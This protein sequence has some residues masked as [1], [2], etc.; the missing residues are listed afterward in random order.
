MK[1]AESRGMVGMAD[2]L[3]SQAQ[4]LQSLTL[5]ELAEPT[6]GGEGEESDEHGFAPGQLGRT[7]HGRLPE[8]TRRVLVQLLRGPYVRRASHPK[9]WAALVR[10]EAP[11]REVLANLF[12]ELIIDADRSLAF[13]RN[14]EWAQVDVPRVIRSTPLT[15]LD[16][17]LVLHLRQLLLRGTDAS[18]RV[19]VGRDDL[20]EALAAYR[21]ATNT[22]P[23][24]FARRIN[25]SVEKLKRASVLLAA[26]EAERYE[27]SPILAIVFDADEVTAVTREVHGLREELAA[28]STARYA[29]GDP[30]DPEVEDDDEPLIDLEAP[31]G[32]AGVARRAFEEDAR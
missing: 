25:A 20:D 29:A 30:D 23:A 12:L 9:L 24:T 2:R 19:F 32:S 13:V 18:G 16:T 31:D 11:V 4:S 8:E 21:P 3:S 28:R 10:D 15:L 7:D 5:A 1:R 14:A 22:D 27:V 17:A 6:E 26:S